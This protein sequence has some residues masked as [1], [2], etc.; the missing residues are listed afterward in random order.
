MAALV[1]LII[2]SIHV[3]IQEKKY[4]FSEKMLTEFGEEALKKHGVKDHKA[5]FRYIEEKLEKK[6]PGH[7][8]PREHREWLFV[9]CGG[10]MG[11]MYLLHASM[12]EYVL[13]F[14][15]AVETS[16]HSG[17]YWANI[18]DVVVQG[19]FRQ[20]REGSTVTLVHGPGTLV[21]HLW[22]EATSIHLEEGTWMFEYGRG[23]IPSTLPF[24][25]GDTILSTQDYY[26]VFKM[27]KVYIISVVQE[28]SQGNF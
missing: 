14:G 22:F 1:A 8:L 12:T 26:T 11:S 15:S 24:A 7:I 9:N 28:L 3:W 19:N 20:W 6:F 16:G 13:F 4:V 21:K 5:V 17:R 23:F 25:L 10:W 2:G 18:S 27:L